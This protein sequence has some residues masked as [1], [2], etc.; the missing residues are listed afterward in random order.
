MLIKKHLGILL[1]LIFFFI[2]FTYHTLYR[3]WT[4]NSHAFDLGIYTQAI[5]L[6]SQGLAPLSTLK[7]MNILGDHFGPILFLISPIYRLFPFPETLLITQALFVSISGIFIY[8][9]ALDKLQD[10]FKSLLITGVYLSFSGILTAV[11]FDFHLATISVLPL[12]IMLYSWYFKR[13]RLYWL[14]IFLALLFKEDIPLF[15]VGLGLFSIL[16]KERKIGLTTVIIGFLSYYII[17]YQIMS[18][19]AQG[20]ENA[21]I[22]SVS[23]SSISS[24]FDSPTKVH[25]IITLYGQFLFL[26]FLSALSWLTVFPYLFIRFASNQTHYWGL[27]FHYN[28]NLA[29]FLAVS[30]I[31]A[32]SK[33]K[34]PRFQIIAYL[35]LALLMENLFFN[36]LISQTLKFN[37]Q[38]TQPFNYINSALK[39]VPVKAA[40]SVQSPLVPHLS[41]RN[42]IY[43]YPEVLDAKYII[44]DE[45]LSQYPMKDKEF[46]ERI[47]SLK[48]SKEWTV[49]QQ[50][51]SLYIFKRV[52]S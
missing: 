28:A 52:K 21:Y 13:W 2:V 27:N 44:L 48:N 5:Y 41:N 14:S 50:V 29:P 19:L 42:K 38:D 30:A 32:L 18:R 8:L 23:F 12:S 47:T 33:I 7:H 46:K 22:N 36:K 10:K 24:I 25:T 15:I 39:I 43:L 49:E 31:F 26:P 40:I 20:A 4:Y 37:I 9:I 17:K 16:K 6:Y 45:K 34:I 35:I 1:V 11:N 51:D 3:H